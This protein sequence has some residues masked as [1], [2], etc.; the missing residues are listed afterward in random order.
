MSESKDSK[1]LDKSVSIPLSGDYS[2]HTSLTSAQI[3]ALQ[4]SVRE[5]KKR[6]NDRTKL[7]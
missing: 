4:Y 5:K 6:D 3:K 2:S 7:N 1:Q